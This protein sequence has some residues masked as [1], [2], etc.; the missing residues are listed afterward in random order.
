MCKLARQRLFQS[1]AVEGGEK[2]FSQFPL[3]N[4]KLMLNTDNKTSSQILPLSALPP[5]DTAATEHNI[6]DL[7]PHLA[8]R[9]LTATVTY[10]SIINKN[11][12]VL[13]GSFEKQTATMVSERLDLRTLSL[14]LCSFDAAF[15]TRHGIRWSR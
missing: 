2:T 4:Y 10:S 7:C 12:L 8:F 1:S 15:L 3:F 9:R 6:I 11:I 13:A 14:L 5:I